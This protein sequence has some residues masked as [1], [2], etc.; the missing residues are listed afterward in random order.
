LEWPAIRGRGLGRV[1][2]RRRRC[3]R[4]V[5]RANH[6]PPASSLRYWRERRDDSASLLSAFED[7]RAAAGQRI[8]WP[9]NP[10]SLSS[11]RRVRRAFR[12]SGSASHWG[13]PKPSLVI[14]A[15]G[16]GRARPRGPTGSR[17]SQRPT[18]GRR[19]RR[20]R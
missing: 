19:S 4:V 13:G 12:L 5:G 9:R 15:A 6:A 17:V 10:K 1:R 11:S 14:P 18:R 7:A 2:A 3:N 16:P 8:A 20:R